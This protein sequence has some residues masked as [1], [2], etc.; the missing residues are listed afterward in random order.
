MLLKDAIGEI[1][2]EVKKMSEVCD[3]RIV[4]QSGRIIL[5]VIEWKLTG[6]T[7]R[8]GRIYRCVLLK[9]RQEV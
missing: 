5:R 8:V 6:S 7:W 3:T 1:K 2:K 4:V 9:Y